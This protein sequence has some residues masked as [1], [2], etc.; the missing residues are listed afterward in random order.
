MPKP[1][2]ADTWQNLFYPPPDY[3]YFDGAD[4]FDFEAAAPGLSWN[5]AWWLADAS[6]LAYVT[7]WPRAEEI[8]RANRFDEAHQIGADPHKSTK[9]FLAIR[10]GAAPFA[11]MA[12]RGTNR[13]DKRNL[14]SDFKFLPQDR[15]PYTVHQGFADALDQVWDDEVQPALAAF[16]AAHPGAPVYFTGHSLGAALATLSVPRFSGAPCSLYTIGSPRAGD[17]RLARAVVDKVRYIVRFVNGH[18]IVT[19]FPL[20][21]PFRHTGPEIYIDRNGVIHETIS[22]FGKMADVAQGVTH[23]DG[24]ATLAAIAQPLAYVER[25]MTQDIVKLYPPDPPAYIVGQHT[26]A[27][28]AIHIWNHLEALPHA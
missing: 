26:P 19:E 7:D 3:R 5:N 13:D 16:V 21:L 9:G 18:E 22:T 24:A 10:S 14:F 23:H 28:Y 2:P 15:G 11:V 17:G 4:R 12:F 25:V 27:R 1:L 6:L 20:G 8:L